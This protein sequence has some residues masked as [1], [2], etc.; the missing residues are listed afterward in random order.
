MFIPNSF[1][2][3]DLYNLKMSTTIS[4]FFKPFSFQRYRY[5]KKI[6]ILCSSWMTQRIQCTSMKISIFTREI[7]HCLV[8]FNLNIYIHVC[9]SFVLVL[10][11]RISSKTINFPI[12]WIYKLFLKTYLFI[13]SCMK[14]LLKQ[15]GNTHSIGSLSC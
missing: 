11:V 3:R 9:T 10:F 13:I 5:L 7:P 2:K 4:A 8:E 14:I 15:L 1:S 12:L 6:E